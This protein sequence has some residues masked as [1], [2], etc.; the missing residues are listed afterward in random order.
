MDWT[1]CSDIAV[2]LSR[3]GERPR[4]PRYA[5]TVPSTK[6]TTAQSEGIERF[7]MLVVAQ[8]TGLRGSWGHSPSLLPYA[9][10]DERSFRAQIM[11]LRAYVCNYAMALG[12]SLDSNKL[13]LRKAFILA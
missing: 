1:D 5:W 9:C 8:A 13:A 4:E 6:R 7:I 3:E 11:P 10:Q 12:L 2:W